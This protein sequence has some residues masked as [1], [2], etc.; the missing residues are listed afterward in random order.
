MQSEVCDGQAP[1]V[2]L[3]ALHGSCST[4]GFIFLAF[5]VLSVTST[6]LPLGQTLNHATCDVYTPKTVKT[7]IHGKCYGYCLFLLLLYCVKQ[8]CFGFI[9]AL[10]SKGI[11][12]TLKE[13]LRQPHN[14]LTLQ[15]SLSLRDK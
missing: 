15:V 13:A 9:E 4:R 14:A 5:L 6:K 12:S 3:T 1:L 2:F 10:G 11:L 8:I 7:L